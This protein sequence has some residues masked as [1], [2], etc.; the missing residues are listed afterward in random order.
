[1]KIESEV[2]F[3]SVDLLIKKK[4]E[5]KKKKVKGEYIRGLLKEYIPYNFQSVCFYKSKVFVCGKV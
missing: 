4:K 5:K 3:T 2:F 1:M